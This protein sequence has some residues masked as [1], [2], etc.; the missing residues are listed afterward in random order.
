VGGKLQRCLKRGIG[1][2]ASAAAA[3]CARTHSPP[4]FTR[5]RR[6]ARWLSLSPA[7]ATLRVS[8]GAA[9]ACRAAASARG[10]HSVS[11]L[12]AYALSAELNTIAS[13]RTLAD[14]IA[15]TSCSVRVAWHPSQHAATAEQVRRPSVVDV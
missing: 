2:R 4:S 6:R 14:R 13:A 1:A 7:P 9:R 8:L 11:R 12:R 10:F 3:G 5:S 15:C